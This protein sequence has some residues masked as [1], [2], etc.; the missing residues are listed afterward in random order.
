M[1]ARFALGMCFVLVAGCPCPI[2]DNTPAQNKPRVVLQLTETESA[3]ALNRMVA[4][5]QAR[6][7]T[8]AILV[9][10]P[11]ATQNCD[12]LQA[13]RDQGYEIMAFVRPDTGTLSQLSRADQQQLIGD[14]QT[15]LEDCLGT[16]VQGFRATRFDQ[17]Q[18]TWEIVDALGFKYDLAFVAGQSYLPGHE[19]DVLPYQSAPYT[20]WAVPMHVA[21]HHGSPAA[22]CDNPFSDLSAE[23]WEALLKSELDQQQAQNQPLMVEFHPSFSG[24]DEGRF[25]AFVD[26]LDYAVAHSAEFLSVPDYVAWAQQQTCPV[27]NE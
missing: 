10:G 22:F 11:F 20:F 6:N 3:D 15:A 27:C 18:D 5:L 12:Q 21:D 4:E 8:A 16:P 25:Q 13:L 26:F 7:L 9:N 14:T 1:V 19:A 24:V 2:C 23:D 17:N